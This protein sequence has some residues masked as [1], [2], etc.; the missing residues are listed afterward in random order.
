MTRCLGAMSGIV[1][2]SRIHPLGLEHINPLEQAYKW[3]GLVTDADIERLKSQA[4]WPFLEIMQMISERADSSGQTLVIADWSNLDFIADK[5]VSELAGTFLHP[6]GFKTHMDPTSVALVR[7]PI[8]QWVHL[9][10]QLGDIAPSIKIFMRG[11]RRFSE[12]LTGIETILFEDFLADPSTVLQTL[13]S[14]LDA[15]FN[16]DWEA[17]W[18]DY[19]YVM[20]EPARKKPENEPQVVVTDEIMEAFEKNADYAPTVMKLGYP[21]PN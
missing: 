9:Q 15:P 20:S 11:Y 17:G 19:R 8:D 18:K 6:T 21:N 4:D 10:N 2:L 1:M 5:P 13:C 16:P 14:C 7:H 3:F 12:C